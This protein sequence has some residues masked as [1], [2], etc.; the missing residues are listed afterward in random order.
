[1][2][3]VVTEF[4]TL[5]GV[6]EAP[7]EWSF[8][9]F[10]DDQGAFKNDE[11]FASD[12]QLLGRITYEGFAAAWP[13]MTDTGE[14]GERMN[15]MPK[16]VVSNTLDKAEW[17]NSHIIKGNI[18]DEI[19]KLKQQ[20]GGDLLVAGSAELVQFLIKNQLVDRYHLLVY[21]IV[22]GKGKR[23]FQDGTDT[24]LKLIETK[25]FGSGV[26]AMIYEPDNSK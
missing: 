17:T 20:P 11:L 19:R 12:A 9:Y 3:L 22:V 25:L 4:L 16:Y 13:T 14:F 10:T 7:N 23:L 18:A 26:V 6:M 2:R 21:P 8:P 24:K 5:D 15:N 1:M